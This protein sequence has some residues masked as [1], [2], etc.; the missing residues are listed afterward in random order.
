MRLRWLL[1]PVLAGAMVM[2]V[3]HLPV[4]EPSTPQPAPRPKLVVLV[5]FDQMRGDYLKKWQPLFGEGGFK[6]LQTDGAWFTN[7]HYPYAYTLTAAGHTS[8][9]T[10]TTPSRH[11]V[12]ANEWYDRANGE[13]VNS[14]T[15]TPDEIANGLGPYRRKSETVGD[16]LM[17]LLKGRVASMSIKDRAA[18]LMAALRAQICY[19]FNPATGNFVTSRYYRPDPHSWVTKFNKAKHADQ[20][21]GQSWNYFKPKL[22][23]KAHSSRDDFKGEGTGY[24]Q[25]QTF[26]HPFQLGTGKDEK[27]NKESYYNA[28][29]CSPMGNE[30]L[31][32][33]VQQ[34]IASEKLGQSESVDLL[35]VSFTSNDYI[36]HTWGPDSQEVLDVT[37]RSD[38]LMKKLLDLLDDKVGKGN[39]YLALSGD[40]GVCP[41]PEFAQKQGKDAGRIAPELLTTEAEAFLNQRFLPAGQKAPW[42]IVPR[43]M[44]TWMYFNY[45]TL[46][47]L[48]LD[49]RVVE[50]AL[51]DWFK[52]QPGIESA[53]TRTELERDNPD[54]SER[55]LQVRRSYHPACSGDVMVIA[56]PYHIFSPPNLAENPEKNPN[57]RATHGMPHDY[58]THVPL[59]VYGPRI[60]PGTRDELVRPQ[61]MASILAEALGVPA[62]AHATYPLPGGLFKK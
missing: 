40:H 20:W 13:S 44:N 24:L 55:Y 6:R 61:A 34:A 19:W 18:I 31:F 22:D 48:G 59:L 54:A 58:D 27:E 45:A 5:V 52:A 10:G 12:I 11:G 21:L 4:A 15:P 17:R 7:C 37:L 60:A 43:R 51:A 35:C 14:V 39:Y 47:G 49:R 33:F 9:V 53:F 62:P 3:W 25:K 50:R 41:L 46:Q 30:L 28:V 38:A 8:L 56:K 29:T 23:Y 2:S 42:F 57:Y 16:V 1:A 26:P 36:G 32:E